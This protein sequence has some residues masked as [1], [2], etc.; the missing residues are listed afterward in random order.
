[1]EEG[2]TFDENMYEL[3]WSETPDFFEELSSA[4]L[5][6]EDI[7]YHVLLRGINSGCIG[8]AIEITVSLSNCNPDEFAFF[9]PDG[10]S[11][12][13]DG[14]NDSYYIPNIQY[15][16]P[17]YDLEIFNRY[18]QSL[19]KGDITNPSWDGTNNGSQTATTSGVY[20]YIL[21]FNFEDLK[22]IQGRLYLSK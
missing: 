1:M 6:S 20:F 10:F 3:V 22:P 8:E 18:G 16:Y 7:T 9:I 21:N 13:N 12:N 11:P 5:L 4:D 17:D 2:I 15:F 14:T 19:F